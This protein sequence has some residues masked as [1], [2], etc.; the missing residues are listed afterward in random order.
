MLRNH[1][2]GGDAKWVHRLGERAKDSA[3]SLHL[4][5]KEIYG[6]DDEDILGKNAFES[7][8]EYMQ[9]GPVVAM[10]IEGLNAV[11]MMRKMVGATLPF[12]AEMGTIR[13]DFSVDTPA[14]ANA[15]GRAI[16]NVIHAS[17][18]P[19]EAEKEIQLWFEGET[20]CDYSLGDE[21]I[22]YCKHY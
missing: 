12:S 14:V 11:P 9:S 6:S 8:V 2:P 1:Y 20:I 17:E 19:A 21:D 16:H 13:G 22:M 7:L 4:S 5:P 3:N 10:V 15:E 18:I